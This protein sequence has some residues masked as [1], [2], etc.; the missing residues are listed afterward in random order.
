MFNYSLSPLVWLSL[1]LFAAL[2]SA[3]LAD[4][5]VDPEVERRHMQERLDREIQGMDHEKQVA[6]VKTMIGEIPLQK[7][8]IEARIDKPEPGQ[9]PSYML[10][11]QIDGLSRWETFLKSWLVNKEAKSSSESAPEDL[12]HQEAMPPFSNSSPISPG[13]ALGVLFLS[14][15]IL[16]GARRALTTSKAPA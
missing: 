7:S 9:M 12:L 1:L 3:G 6:K 5:P 4:I 8:S 11:K 15:G 10:R 14:A 13:Y 2:S 16:L